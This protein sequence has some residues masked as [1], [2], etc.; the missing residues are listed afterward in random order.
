MRIVSKNAPNKALKNNVSAGLVRV[1]RRGDISSSSQEIHIKKML[2]TLHDEGLWLVCDC[3]PELSLLE[4]PCLSVVKRGDVLF[5]R[6]LSSRHSHLDTCKFK[7]V[8][9]LPWF[10]H[11]NNLS[12]D[13]NKTKTDMHQCFSLYNP[14]AILRH[15]IKQSEWLSYDPSSSFID[16]IKRVSNES[17]L[18]KLDIND[19]EIPLSDILNQSPKN[20]FKSNASPSVSLVI[21]HE[22]DWMKRALLRRD[23]DGDHELLINGGISPVRPFDTKNISSGPYLALVC[24]YEIEGQEVHSCSYIPVA[25]NKNPIPVL[26]ESERNFSTLFIHYSMWMIKHN[27]LEMAIGKSVS[28]DGDVLNGFQI[29]SDKKTK[30]I[31][32]VDLEKIEIN[33]N[34]ISIPNNWCDCDGED[35]KKKNNFLKAIFRSELLS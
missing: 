21:I 13:A 20:L 24:K 29:S 34:I 2:K 26:S 31:Q 12:V 25:E 28:S 8:K 15:I 11:Q 33:E 22:I 6:N 4:S 7:Y 9:S 3:R 10:S 18:I 19:R 14:N 35:K 1:W 17:H 5:L 16:L 30:F 27:G 23:I 32:F